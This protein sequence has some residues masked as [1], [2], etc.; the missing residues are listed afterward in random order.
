MNRTDGSSGPDCGNPGGS[1][2]ERKA[3]TLSQ[4]QSEGPPR[5]DGPRFAAWLGRRM[6]SERLSVED[7]FTRSHLP[8][9]TVDNLRRGEPAPYIVAKRG[10]R[11]LVPPINT[12]AALAF[13]LDLRFSYLASKAGLDDEGDRWRNFTPAELGVIALALSC[14]PNTLDDRL[15]EITHPVIHRIK[16]R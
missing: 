3:P 10:Q 15:R 8:R 11:A 5:F 13:G 16:G 4:S 1:P 2:H 9:G 14:D 7:V 6:E 12:I